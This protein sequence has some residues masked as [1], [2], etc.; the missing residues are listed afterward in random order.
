[1]Q[2]RATVRIVSISPY[3]RDDRDNRKDLRDP[4]VEGCGRREGPEYSDL[5][6]E[7]QFANTPLPLTEQESRKEFKFRYRAQMVLQG[8]LAPVLGAPF[9]LIHNMLA[10]PHLRLNSHCNCGGTFEKHEMTGKFW[11]MKSDDTRR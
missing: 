3:C 4:N 2:S 1:M 7:A 6:R 5:W 11:S 9:D 10:K 8:R